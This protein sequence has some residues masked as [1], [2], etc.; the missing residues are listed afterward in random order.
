[1]TAQE[2]KH[3]KSLF[4]LTLSQL[5]RML[6]YEGKHGD[7]VVQHLLSGERTIRPAQARL[8][9]AYLDGYRPDDWP[10]DYHKPSD[11]TSLIAY[12]VDKT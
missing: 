11:A 8:M 10:N 9:Q 7:R 2:L 5:A 12:Y 1:M 4:G 6:G 3:A